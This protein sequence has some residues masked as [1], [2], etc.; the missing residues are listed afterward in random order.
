MPTRSL[1]N[2]FLSG[3]QLPSKYNSFQMSLDQADRT[4]CAN[5]LEGNQIQEGC[6][7]VW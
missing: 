7:L 1:V 6:S 3:T 5:V 4:P 2:Y